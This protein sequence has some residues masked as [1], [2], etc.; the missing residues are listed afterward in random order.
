MEHFDQMHVSIETANMAGIIL[1][2]LTYGTNIEFK[3]ERERRHLISCP[4]LVGFHL[5]LFIFL[6][7][8]HCIQSPKATTGGF[9]QNWTLLAYAVLVFLL[10]TAGF[11]IQTLLNHRAFVLHRDFPYGGPL[12]YIMENSN[13]SL[14]LSLTTV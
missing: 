11:C 9:S 14:N 5:A 3:S 6:I 7:R 13:D 12:G 8:L 10:A 4:F 2:N 1:S